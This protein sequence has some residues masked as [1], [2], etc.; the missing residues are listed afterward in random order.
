MHYKL[1]APKRTR[2][3]LVERLRRNR[4]RRTSI[5]A[6]GKTR[7]KSAAQARLELLQEAKRSVSEGKMQILKREHERLVAEI[8]AEREAADA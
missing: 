8:L 6:G 4:L 3:D 2:L 7:Y 1:P 5:T